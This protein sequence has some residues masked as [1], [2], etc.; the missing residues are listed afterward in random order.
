M[1]GGAVYKSRGLASFMPCEPSN[2]VARNYI[3]ILVGRENMYENV[4]FTWHHGV[5]EDE[6]AGVSPH[7]SVQLHFRLRTRPGA[8]S[9]G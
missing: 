5:E 3:H 9:R 6:N 2:I 1:V 4:H 8:E 7:S